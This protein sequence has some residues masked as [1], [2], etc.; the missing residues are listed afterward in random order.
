MK[1]AT[2]MM[3]EY[4]QRLLVY[5]QAQKEAYYEMSYDLTA[6]LD[7]P[8]NAYVRNAR[9]RADERVSETLQS[10]GWHFERVMKG[11]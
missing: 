10:I 2:E 3:D 7:A 8:H 9:I 4:Y 11:E 5:R 1:T 6:P